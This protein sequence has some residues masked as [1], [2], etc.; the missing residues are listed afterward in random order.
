[1]VDNKL[2]NSLIN[3]L[4]PIIL[5]ITLILILTELIFQLSKASV[6]FG[7][8]GQILR[9]NVIIQYAFYG[10]LQDW[11]FN[12]GILRWEFAIRYFTYPFVHLSF[13]Q[14]LIATV[15]F[16]A[17]GKMVC[18]IYNGLLFFALV[19]ASSVSGAFFYGLILDDQFPLTGLFPAIYG[20]IGAY[21]YI[22]WISLRSVGAKS[23]NAFTLVAVLLGIQIIFKFLFN[24]T[25]DWIADL[26][27]F[28]TGFLFAFL[29]NLYTL[30][31][32]N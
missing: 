22:L 15:M 6:M 8:S 23:A 11:M 19:F 1:M 24:G 12:N 5:I 2:N 16:L 28:L 30:K 10:S 25:N 29:T 3:P 7:E 21:T 9:N 20:L 32:L 27:G 26:F 17:L 4:P 18:E 13:M 31:R 14:T